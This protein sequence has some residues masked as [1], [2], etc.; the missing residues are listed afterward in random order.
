MFRI[1]LTPRVAI[2][3]LA[4]LVLTACQQIQP[5]PK[6]ASVPLRAEVLVQGASLQ[7]GANGIYFDNQDRLYVGSVG[8]QRITVMDPETGQLLDKFGPEQGV[9]GADDL[10]NGPDG[11]LYWTSLMTGEVGR[12]TPDGVKSG[13]VVAPGVNPITFSDD[14]RLFV[15]LD[16]MGDTLYELDPELAEPPRLIAENLGWLNAFD[17]GPD[18][19]LYG[20]LIQKGMVARIDVDSGSVTPVAGGFDFPVAVKFDPQGRLHLIEATSGKVWRI[21]TVT[22]NKEVVATIERGLDNLAF[23]SQGRLFVSRNDDGFIVEV[24][25]N[26]TTRTVSSGGMIS[27]YGIAV[28]ADEQGNESIFVADVTA[29]RQFDG[30]T[31]STQNVYHSLLFV[32]DPQA[33]MTELQAPM[34]A[35]ADGKQLVLSSWFVNAVQVWDSTTRKV[36]ESYPDFAVPLNAIRFQGDL[37]VAELET[38]RVVRASGDN[39]AERTTLAADL[40]VPMGLAASDNNLWVS[41]WAKGTVLQLIAGGEL[42]A[43]PKV[44]ATGLAAPE[45]MAIALDGSLLVVESGAGRLSRIDLNSGKVIPIVEG[46]ELGASGP[47]TMPPI[48]GFSGVAVGPSGTIYVTGDKADVVYHLVAAS[49]AAKLD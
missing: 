8:G 1:N 46:L 35:A 10:I 12:M 49:A 31:G 20:P 45:G 2:I 30:Q 23:D 25:P 40:A 39:P 3:L 6:A 28:L 19:F 44:V 14:G 37:I 7:G 42:L 15:A 43:E 17:F 24:L 27:A 9:A 29:L 16:F 21:D 22:G 11:S 5:A 47:P 33:Q 48:W 26:G 36:V 38:N 4:A 41:E 18:G 32:T 34:T 13:Q